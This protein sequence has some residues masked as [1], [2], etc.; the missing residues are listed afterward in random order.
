MRACCGADV[1]PTVSW[2]IHSKTPQVSVFR[3]ID[4]SY[5]I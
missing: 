1:L 3:V 2:K 5:N 4:I